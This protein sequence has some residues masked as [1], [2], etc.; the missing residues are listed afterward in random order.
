MS[1]IART[2]RIPALASAVARNVGRTLRFWNFV[3][4]VAG[5]RLGGFVHIASLKQD[6]RFAFGFFARIA[7]LADNA[8][9]PRCAGRVMAAL[10]TGFH[11]A[12]QAANSSLRDMQCAQ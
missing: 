1:L 10:S 8:F 2:L 9:D 11:R 6:L 7:V 5:E 4:A 3:P 12:A